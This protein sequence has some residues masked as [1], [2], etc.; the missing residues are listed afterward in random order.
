MIK[1]NCLKRWSFLALSASLI[2]GSGFSAKANETLSRYREYEFQTSDPASDGSDHFETTIEEEGV[3]YTLSSISTEVLSEEIVEGEAYFYDSPAFLDAEQVEQPPETMIQDGSTYRLKDA[4]LEPAIVEAR[5]QYV[6][7]EVVLNDLEWLELVPETSEIVVTDK[8]TGQEFTTTMPFLKIASQSER[9]TDTFTFPIHISHTDAD[10]FMLGNTRIS[11]LDDLNNYKREFLSYLGLPANKY[12]ITRIERNGSTAAAYGRKLV[13]DVTAVYGGEASMPASEGQRYRCT[14]VNEAG[15]DQT[16]YTMKATAIY[17]VSHP[18]APGNFGSFF[19]WLKKNPVP[20]ILLGGV[21]I[22]LLTF[23]IMI[24][25]A[26]KKGRQ[27][28][29]WR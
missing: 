9:W 10:Y 7:S 1:T 16:I 28:V 20:A 3:I 17:E 2:L 11:S 21:F 29:K 27:R 6:E 26:Q 15:P 24:L 23:I 13:Y 18:E 4:I 12:E 25:I 14:Y 19:E 22:A 8:V 5:T